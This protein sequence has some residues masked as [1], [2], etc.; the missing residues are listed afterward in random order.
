MALLVN[1]EPIE[2]D[3]LER[4]AASMRQRLQNIPP[5]EIEARRI[6]PAVL[7]KHRWD[8][9]RDNVIERTLLRQEALKD[10]TPILPRT[11][12]E[13]LEERKRLE[14]VEYPFAHFYSDND[15]RHNSIETR[16]RLDRLFTRI[17]EKVAPPKNKE[18]AEFYRKNKAQFWMPEMVRAAHIVKNVDEKTG[19]ATARAAIESVQGRLGNGASFEELADQHSDCPGNGGD[20]GYFARGQ[21]VEAFDEVVFALG[22]G[23][24]SPIFRT[25][26]GFHI[27]KLLDRK[28]PA[29][30]ALSEVQGTIQQKLLQDKQVRAIENF[31]DHLKEKADIRGLPAESASLVR[32]R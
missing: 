9:S 29:L 7:E 31:V 26:F 30:L 14:G 1:G 11:I 12:E 2:D 15:P 13:A 8:W 23:E 4:E 17:T 24:I 20:L 5:E 21:M 32:K 19:E 6:D 16:I 22:T 18:I 27:A 10:E 25:A 3:I 28:V